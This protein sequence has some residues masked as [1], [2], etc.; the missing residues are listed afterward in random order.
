MH[1]IDGTHDLLLD[2]GEFFVQ[3][4]S[5]WPG[6]PELAP[7][8]LGRRQV[9]GR[10]AL[11]GSVEIQS[12]GRWRASVAVDPAVNAQRFSRVASNVSDRYDA[13]VALWHA[14]SQAY[15]GSTAL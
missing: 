7:A 3:L 4:D 9:T 1:T 10:A 15:D 8:F 13:I 2:R 5:D 6:D 11:I 14:R 12:D